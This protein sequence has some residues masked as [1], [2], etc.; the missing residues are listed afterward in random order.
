LFGENLKHRSWCLGLVPAWQ[1]SVWF[2][3]GV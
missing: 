3:R 1:A 2:W